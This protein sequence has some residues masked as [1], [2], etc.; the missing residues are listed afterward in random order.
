MAREHVRATPR[1]ERDLLC[2]DEELLDHQKSIDLRRCIERLTLK[3]Y[4]ICIDM[5]PPVSFSAPRGGTGGGV[6]AAARGSHIPCRIDARASGGRRMNDEWTSKWT[7]I[8]RPG[9]R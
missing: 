4:Q 7:T 8:S 3:I 5:R 1:Y 6:W 9:G 2:T